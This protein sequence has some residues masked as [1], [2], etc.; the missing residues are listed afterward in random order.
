MYT[1][2]GNFSRRNNS[3]NAEITTNEI[4][5][6]GG[7]KNVY[8]GTY[9]RGERAGEECV[10]KMFKSGSVY[11]VAYFDVELKVIIY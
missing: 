5:A 10:V 7:F 11:E 2:N 8:K 1:N 3:T 9:T 4:Y 6:T